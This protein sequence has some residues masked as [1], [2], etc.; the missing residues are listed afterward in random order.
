[1]AMKP[2]GCNHSDRR[3]GNCCDCDYR[4]SSPI[5]ADQQLSPSPGAFPYNHTITIIPTMPVLPVAGVWYMCTYDLLDGLW[6]V[7]EVIEQ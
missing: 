3:S 4:S 2:G 7:E 1:M 6:Q 5:A